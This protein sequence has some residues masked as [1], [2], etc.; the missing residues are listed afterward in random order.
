MLLV[1]QMPKIVQ[2]EV[3]S[4]SDSE[5]EAGEVPQ[6]TQR[7]ALSEAKLKALELARVKAAQ[8]AKQ[9]SAVTKA[10]KEAETAKKM[11]DKVNA[12]ALRQ[13]AK[14]IEACLIHEAP[15]AAPPPPRTSVEGG[16]YLDDIRS[17]L[18]ALRELLTKP[19]LPLEQVQEPRKAK[20]AARP[21]QTKVT[22]TVSTQPPTRVEAFKA[23]LGR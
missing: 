13:K 8:K 6:K 9:R 16:N 2:A 14:A 21:N 18:K 11:A 3:P 7:K 12:F 15:P 22:T 1:D 19:A 17:E 5:M 4:D 23:M 10:A 20:K